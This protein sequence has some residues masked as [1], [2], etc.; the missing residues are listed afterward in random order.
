MIKT[1]FLAA[2]FLI[3]SYSVFGQ[4]NDPTAEEKRKAEHAQDM[5]DYSVPFYKIGKIKEIIVETPSGKNHYEPKE[6]CSDWKMT[7]ARAKYFF[8]HPE[9]VS[10]NAFW[11]DYTYSSC[12]SK[13]A[14]K[15][16]NGDEGSWTIYR[17][18]TGY[19]ELT[20][21]KSKG[22]LLHLFCQKCEDQVW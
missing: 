13:G 22:K 2:F 14:V 18:G 9:H 8:K 6:D 12:Y 19:I 7:P 15:F 4:I 17:P 1:T 21:G 3:Q 10:R 16:S 11:H 5:K 20:K